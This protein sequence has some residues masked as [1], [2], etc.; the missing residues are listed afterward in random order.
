MAK[1]RIGIKRSING[2]T[3]ITMDTKNVRRFIATKA[4][5]VSIVKNTI[6]TL[7]TGISVFRRSRNFSN[8]LILL[9]SGDSSRSDTSVR[10]LRLIESCMDKSNAS[11]REELPSIFIS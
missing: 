9:N 11:L 8:G 10:K 6:T 2:K 1:A 5:L 7:T 4:S 3:R